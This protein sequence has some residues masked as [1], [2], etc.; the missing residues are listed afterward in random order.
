MRLL[1]R[2]S[3][4]IRQPCW[5]AHFEA[6]YSLEQ[7]REGLLIEVVLDTAVSYVQKLLN[8][9]HAW[10]F[11]T[12][13]FWNLESGKNVQSEMRKMGA[14]LIEEKSRKC[15][16]EHF[17]CLIKAFRPLWKKGFCC[18]WHFVFSQSC[19]AVY[20]LIP[21]SYPHQ[22]FGLKCAYS[23]MRGKFLTGFLR[24]R[25]R[26]FLVCTAELPVLG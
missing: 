22:I 2:S 19:R 14:K 20:N 25:E 1:V 6:F 23:E 15:K 10:R 24:A 11:S 13:F 12:V 5:S 26:G 3:P 21:K 4:V 17:C 16:L 7:T 18:C 9:S 8:E